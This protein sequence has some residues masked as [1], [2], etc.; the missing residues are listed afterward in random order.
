MDSRSARRIGKSAER[1]MFAKTRMLPVCMKCFEPGV[2]LLSCSKQARS[3]RKNT[4]VGGISTLS[5]I[6]RSVGQGCLRR[7]SAICSLKR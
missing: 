5:S 7:D 4:T 1:S 2:R 3:H 6:P